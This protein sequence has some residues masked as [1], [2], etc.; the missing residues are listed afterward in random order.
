MA[1]V[2]C[3]ECGKEV[4]DKAKNCI[5]CGAPIAPDRESQGSGVDHLTTVQGTSKKLKLQQAI[6]AVL[7]VAGGVGMFVA[8]DL[9][10]NPGTPTTIML[11]GLVW[12]IVT[13]VRTW[14]HHG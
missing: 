5:G 12:Y 6:A 2:K 1:L 8:G 4:S 3:P 14:W 9:G 13:R 11:I 10:W 7:F